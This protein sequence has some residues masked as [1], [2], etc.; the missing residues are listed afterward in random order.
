MQTKDLAICLRT[1]NYSETSQVVTLLT[2][3][4]GKVAAIAKGS[5]R[6]KSS[7]DGPIE[8][9]S[10]GQVMFTMKD[11]GGQLATLTDL[12][13]QPVFRRL[14]AN[15]QALN[16]AL[17]AA[18]LTE[19]FLENHDPHPPLFDKLIKFL[20]TLQEAEDSA[21]MLAWLI[22]Y[23]LRLLEETGQALLLDSCTNC[24]T[25][26]NSPS[27]KGQ[28][29][30]KAQSSP[31]VKGEYPE[32]GRGYYFSSHANGLLCEG[33]EAAFSEKRA[34]SPGL[35]DTLKNPQKLP[36]T[37]KDQLNQIEQLLIYH[38]TEL[39]GKPPKMAKFFI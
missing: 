38:F 39:L 4:D 33:C 3:R 34:I 22:L 18:E 29:P 30:H 13:Q 24:G 9:F 23:Q 21:A 27:A 32:G 16:A 11:S 5:R 36:K 28:A 8:I 25:T 35:I 20:E 19:A 7:F 6:P 1:V 15:L 37:R 31:P 2:R 14:H 17:F 10:F 12:Q 26:I